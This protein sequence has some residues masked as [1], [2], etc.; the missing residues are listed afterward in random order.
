M[1]LSYG[2]VPMTRPLA[3][4]TPTVTVWSKPNGLPMAMTHSPTRR[5]S[6]S[7]RLSVGSGLS[8]S[9][10]MRARSVFG[11]VPMT[12]ASYS[13]PFWSLTLISVARSTT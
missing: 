10:L 6:L 4:T 9:I 2:P 3:L 11:S 5:A 1:K 8:A 7:P 12:L 13:L